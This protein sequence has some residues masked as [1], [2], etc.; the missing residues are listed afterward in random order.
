MVCFPLMSHD[1]ASSSNF[2][3]IMLA[4]AQVVDIPIHSHPSIVSEDP[5]PLT[6]ASLRQST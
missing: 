5:S 4:L 1:S 3:N 2:R 6:L